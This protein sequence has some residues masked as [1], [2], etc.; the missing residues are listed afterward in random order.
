MGRQL[1]CGETVRTVDSSIGLRG[2]GSARIGPAGEGGLA[3][4]VMGPWHLGAGSQSMS[5]VACVVCE[6]LELSTKRP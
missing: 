2:A 3:I 5:R 6:A 4:N 1:T